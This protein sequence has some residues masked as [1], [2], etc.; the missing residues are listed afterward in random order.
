[1]IGTN[2]DKSFREKPVD[3]ITK[4]NK[5]IAPRGIQ[6][7]SPS[8]GTNGR[9]GKVWQLGARVDKNF[10]E[11]EHFRLLIEKQVVR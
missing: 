7:E 3:R 1:L 5:V 8:A 11:W 9:K 2:A 4:I 6:Q 10:L